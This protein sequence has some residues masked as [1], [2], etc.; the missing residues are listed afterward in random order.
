MLNNFAKLV[1]LRPKGGRG[2]QLG[3]VLLVVALIQFACGTIFAQ[4]THVL[5]EDG[6]VFVTQIDLSPGESYSISKDKSGVIWVALDPALL[7]TKNDG[8]QGSKQIKPGDAEVVGVNEEL[9]FQ[10]QTGQDVRL[11]LVKPKGPHQDLTVG[12]FL[13]SGSLEDASDRNATLLVAV[14]A[15]RFRDTRNIG[16]ESEWKP[17]KPDI[18]T[19]RPGSVRWIRSGIHHFKNLD[20]KA[21]KLISIEW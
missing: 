13:A 14:S 2:A 4:Q 18:I 11:I 19:M 3:Y 9:V 1:T 21:A 10:G 8:L 12:P 15:C 6:K 16:D 5:L 17:G 7:I 20:P